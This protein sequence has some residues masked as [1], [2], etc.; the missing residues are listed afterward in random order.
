M[1]PLLVPLGVLALL[2][3]PIQAQT[4]TTAR[5]VV[6]VDSAR[7]AQLYVSNRLE[8]HPVADYARAI[9]EKARTDSIFAA[10]S[11]GV[12]RYEK[13][14]YRSRYG[15][16]DIPVYVF[17]PLVSR[18]A[19]AHAALVWVHGGVHGN[20]DQNYLPFIIE[21]TQRGYVVVAPEYRGSTGYGATFHNAID[22]GGREL[23]DVEDAVDFLQRRSEVD[24]ARIG[25]MG[26]SHGGYITA[27]L[28]MRGEQARFVAG[29]AIVPVTNL[30]FRLS[31]K[32]PSYQRSFAT[33]E[34]LRGLPFEKREEYI[35]RSPYYHVDALARPLLV[36]A[37][38]NDTDV[39][40]V[41]GQMLI[42]ALRARKPE[43][44]ET[45]VYVDPAPG[46]ASQGH[47]F[48]RRVN[49]ETLLREDSPAQIDS[50]NL[51]WE[52]FARHLRPDSGPSAAT[53]A[54]A[55][56]VGFSGPNPWPAIRQERIRTLLPAAM[57][58]TGVDAWVSLFRENANDPLA[59]HLG[60]ENAGAPS[61][62][63]VTRQ[64]DGVRTVMLS[65]FGEAIALR[66]LGVHDSVVVYDGSAAALS[67]AIAIRLRAA[68]AKRIAINS[69][70]ASGIADGMSATQRRSLERALGPEWS[71]RLVSSHELVQAWLAIKLPAEV[72]IMSR[73]A[74]LTAQ[75][76]EE[77]YAQVVPGVTRDS[78][79][80][81]Y[82]KARMRDLGVEDGWSP[83]QNPS[84]NSG[85][86]R[87]HSHA[88]DRVIQPGDVIQT[89]FGI[90]VHGVW[91][92]DIQRFAYVL[93]PGETAPPADIQRKWAIAKAGSRAAFAAMRPGATGAQVDSAQRLIMDRERS[94]TVP[95]STGHPVGY[96]AH[97]AGPR[98]NRA[99]RRP[100]R[101]GMTFAYDGFMAWALPGSDGTKWGEGTK[102]ISVEE[103]TVITRDGARFLTSPQEELILI[104]ARGP[105]RP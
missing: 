4:S 81:R 78:D 73:A 8:D 43:R 38:T 33:Q 9:T 23:D 39:D 59:L 74:R 79:I 71:T 40:F 58:E 86:D 56:A 102:T 51:T 55:D 63:I 32:G 18:G 87:G 103:M 50:W 57:R 41:E 62:V 30:V 101:E 67:Q 45:K 95:W 93:R 69:G 6:P 19:R 60:G 94:T 16:L 98:L 28:L 44:A 96:W 29:A 42:D 7:A 70:E 34:A 11:A 53:G 66:E 5:R 26:W 54:F 97:D 83:S 48:S 2:A 17:A 65:G 24:P 15:D 84:V 31:Y 21:A 100:L 80:A 85:P 35:R 14:T 47:T 22:Y 52:F 20:W 27:L 92:T 49:R 12:M 36:H 10:R 1:R 46:P 76:E 13:T 90:R 3:S 75:L 88:S 61:A 72:E 37:A 64:G 77:A 105:A 25:I 104:P 68:G 89:D 99:E 91:V 82:L